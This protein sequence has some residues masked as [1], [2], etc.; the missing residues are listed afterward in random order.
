M[1]QY[2]F[3]PFP[4]DLTKYYPNTYY[5]F[6]LS[7]TSASPIQR[8]KG[9]IWFRTVSLPSFERSGFVYSQLEACELK[10]PALEAIGSLS[11]DRSS[12]ILDVGC[13]SG[14]LL[15]NLKRLGFSN[16][17][18]IDPYI[19]QDS[20]NDMVRL[21]KENII[22][23]RTTEKFDVIVFYHSLE[24]IPDPVSALRAAEYLLAPGG[25]I[26]IAVPIPNFA[27]MIKKINS[28]DTSY[29]L[30]Q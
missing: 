3:L 18:G 17:T 10:D 13:G 1:G 29:Q 19:S 2:R 15:V 11:L 23:Y 25:I 6:S 9:R 24:H 27:I 30:W 16:L 8:L 20:S 26:L 14:G 12:R 28:R 5:S 22:K 4:P 21:F 7:P